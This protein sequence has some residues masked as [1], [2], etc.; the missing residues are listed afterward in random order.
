MISQPPERTEY[1]YKLEQLPSTNTYGNRERSFPL[2]NYTL[3]WKCG[4][5]VI[6]SVTSNARYVI[7]ILNCDSNQFI[8]I[9]I[10]I[11]IIVPTC[12]CNY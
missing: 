10:Y 11:F 9:N 1:T 12:M 5:E 2:R 7:I 8:N 6:A 3:E 4:M